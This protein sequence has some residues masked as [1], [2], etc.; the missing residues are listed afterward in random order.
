MESLKRV[1]K[2]SEESESKK[3]KSNEHDKEYVM[4]YS[5]EELVNI[6]NNKTYEKKLI[7]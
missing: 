6:G 4:R 3:V 1:R 2:T 5:I 7:K